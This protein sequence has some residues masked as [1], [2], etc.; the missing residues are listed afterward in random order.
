MSSMTSLYGEP[1][2]ALEEALPLMQAITQYVNR[3][4]TSPD[5]PAATRNAL[6]SIPVRNALSM[7]ER[8]SMDRMAAAEEPTL[9][10]RLGLALHVLQRTGSDAESCLIRQSLQDLQEFLGRYLEL[11]RM[12]AETAL[13]E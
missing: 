1:S 13:F 5:L 12:H 11:K 3:A 4:Y 10:E 7:I 2:H 6:F 9:L 8:A